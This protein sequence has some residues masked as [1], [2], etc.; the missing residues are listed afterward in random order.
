M[1][2]L[3][4]EWHMESLERSREID[5]L[6]NEIAELKRQLGNARHRP[7]P[8]D[9]SGGPTFE[10]MKKSDTYRKVVVIVSEVE[11]GNRIAA[12]H[13]SIEDAI[14]TRKTFP[15]YKHATIYVRHDIK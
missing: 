12:F 11:V 4:E 7:S 1:S 9:T 14:E 2:D 6:K 8:R 5:R 13:H 15:L 10:E 3:E